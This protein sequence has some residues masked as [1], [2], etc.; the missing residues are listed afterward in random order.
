MI[1]NKFLVTFIIFNS[2]VKQVW[3]PC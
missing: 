3:P 2:N 1:E